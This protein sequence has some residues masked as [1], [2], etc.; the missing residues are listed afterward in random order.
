M[1]KVYRCA[2]WP[3]LCPYNSRKLA[4]RSKHCAFLGYNNLHKGFKCLDISTGRVYISRDVVFDEEVFPFSELH[5]NAGAIL[6][7]EI[8]LLPPNLLGP[9]MLV[10]GTTI[11]STDVANS[12]NILPVTTYAFSPENLALEGLSGGGDTQC[13]HVL[14]P[15]E[16]L[17]AA[18]VTVPSELL[19]DSV[20]CS[21]GESPSDAAAN[22]PATEPAH[23][24]ASHAPASPTRVALWLLLWCLRIQGK[25]RPKTHAQSGI[26]KPKTYTDGM[27]RYGLLTENSE[28]SSLDAALENKNWRRAMDQEY[29][30]LLKNKTWHLVPS[31]AGRN[32][33]DCKWVY[34]IK[35][36]PDGTIDMYKARLVAKGFKQRYGIDYEDTFSPVVKAATIRLVLSIAVSNNWSLRQLDVQNGFLHG[37]LEEVF[38]RQPLG[39]KV[40]NIHTMC[41][42]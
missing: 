4:F 12:S 42:S 3:N 11:S 34:K 37:I 33:I 38:M 5:D 13:K 25:T 20:P 1:L 9:F 23:D 17:S 32:I 21:P 40:R 14:K 10:R 31:Q 16:D 22:D 30:A 7:K 36:K 6:R 41:V 24:T 19:S 28:P 26:R 18:A 15:K 35:H 2:C 29:D 8:S 27:V 39:M